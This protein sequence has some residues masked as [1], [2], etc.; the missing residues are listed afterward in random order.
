MRKKNKYDHSENCR[1]KD[2]EFSR[3]RSLMAK[4][5]YELAEKEKTRKIQR[6]NRKVIT[7]KRH[8]RDDEHTEDLRE[9]K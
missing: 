2:T 4:V 3:F 1:A 5:D 9:V 7:S 6:D 8:K